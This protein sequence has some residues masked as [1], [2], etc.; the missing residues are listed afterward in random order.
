MTA[1]ALWAGLRGL[2]AKVPLVVWLV[3]ALLIWGLYNQHERRMATATLVTQQA[4]AAAATASKVA[5]DKAETAR[6]ADTQ[7]EAINELLAHQATDAAAIARS[8]DAAR[9]LQRQLAADAA[10][11][12]TNDP[13]SIGTGQADRLT[14][15]FGQCVER[16][17]AVAASAASAVLAG[18][19]CERSYDAVKP[20]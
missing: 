11:R 13:A 8:A 14:V 5:A 12:R 7:K 16:Y 20:P 15:V 3:L 2:L 17:R 19:L 10:R 9:R 6:I 1:L 18:Q 4:A